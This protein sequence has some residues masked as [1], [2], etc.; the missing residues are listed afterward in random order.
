MAIVSGVLYYDGNRTAVASTTVGVIA[1]VPI[2]L[3]NTTTGLAV[4]VLTD[5]GGDFKFTNVPIGDYQVVEAYGWKYDDGTLPT[6]IGVIDF[7]TNA[8]VVTML[9]G[10]TVPPLADE[11]HTY[12][13]IPIGSTITN[14][15]CTV[16]NTWLETVGSLDITGIN[17]LNGPVRISPLVLNSNIMVCHTNLIDAADAGT[18]GSF[19]AGTIANTGA[20]NYDPA[21]GP[22]PEIA[23]QFLYAQPDSSKVTPSDGSYTVQNIMNNAHSNLNPTPTPEKSSW[24]RVADH[25]KGNE[26][27]RM[28]VI[29]GYTEGYI[30]GKTTVTVDPNANYLTSYWILN[31]CKQS[32]GYINPEFSAV[33]LDMNGNV[34]YEHNFTDE[35]RVN[36][37]C[38]EWIQ[39]GTIFNA[40]DNTE[41]TIEF[42][43]QGGPQ[44]GNDY[45]LDDVAL[46][47]V[48]ILELNI[49]KEVSCDYA[50]VG[51][52]LYYAIAIKNPTDF[53]ATEIVLTDV[54]SDSFENLE[55]SL[56]GNNW[57]DWTGSLNIDDLYPGDSGN[58]IIRG[59]IKVGITTVITNK[60]SAEVVFCKI[61]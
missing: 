39:I 11:N 28:M 17:M 16:R 10:G 54:L 5:S 27:G 55:F 29:N 24:W 52:T 42:I 59:K 43:S 18:F 7:L 37:E 34:I 21:K 32:S 53:L 35:I 31:L 58:V 56:D 14:L 9:Q 49:T 30:I 20:G 12:V 36:E 23:S 13:A 8:T 25:T 4:A 33:I 45:V 47:K 46:N 61:V 51:G 44:T 60:A 6:A 26:T 19:T 50:T 22:Y 1:N 57:E 48:D 3:Q 15:D 38:P 41:V 2:V 40:G